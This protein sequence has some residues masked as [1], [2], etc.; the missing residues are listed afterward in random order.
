MSD[1]SD[2][3]KPFLAATVPM[4]MRRLRDWRDHELLEYVH[5]P[6]ADVVAY[7]GDTLMFREKG[8][9][10]RTFSDAAKSVACMALLNRDGVTFLGEH[11]CARPH[12]DCPN[13]L[14]GA[15]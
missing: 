4:W 12:S 8:T 15:A 7:Q 14:K 9:T 5:G 10:A 6:G 11:Y 3:L 2:I 13:A 1:R